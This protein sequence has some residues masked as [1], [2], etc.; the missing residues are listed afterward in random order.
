MVCLSL[1]QRIIMLFNSHHHPCLDVH[2][3]PV[4]L[5]YYQ[6]PI[7]I[8]T[9]EIKFLHNSRFSEPIDHSLH[10]NSSYFS[11]N[12]RRCKRD[13][14]PHLWYKVYQCTASVLLRISSHYKLCFICE[15]FRFVHREVSILRTFSFT[16]RHFDPIIESFLALR[17]HIH[18]SWNIRNIFAVRST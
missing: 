6:V 17:T 3:I 11:K 1:L 7:P 18:Y 10:F 13:M 16:P 2:I 14:N 4:M 12:E 9:C 15:L 8:S 5:V